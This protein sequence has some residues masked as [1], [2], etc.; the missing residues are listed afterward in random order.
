MDAVRAT[1][2]AWNLGQ[3]A[4]AFFKEGYDDLA[5]LKTLDKDRLQRV[6]DTVGMKPG[7]LGDMHPHPRS[8]PSP[9][10]SPHPNYP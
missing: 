10:P 7:E 2:A 6:A 8:H 1:L 4:D 9:Y 5:Y 3:Y